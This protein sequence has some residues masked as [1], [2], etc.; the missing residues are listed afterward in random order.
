MQITFCYIDIW[1][2]TKFHTFDY[3]VRENCIDVANEN[4][5]TCF[6][7][8]ENELNTM[9]DDC[10]KLLSWEIKYDYE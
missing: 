10:K 1:D 7:W 6:K 8:F 4:Y 3:E 2:N 9:V 5:E